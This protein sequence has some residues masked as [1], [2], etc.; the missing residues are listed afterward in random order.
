MIS[1]FETAG[2]DVVDDHGARRQRGAGDRGL[3]G[4]DAQGDVGGRRQPL[5]DGDDP[6][7][8]LVGGDWRRA[9][10]GGLPA[11]VEDVG[12]GGGEL[13]P[14]GDGGIGLEEAPAVRERVGRDVDDPHDR[15]SRATHSIPLEHLQSPS[16]APALRTV[17]K[18]AASAKRTGGYR[19]ALGPI[20]H[21]T[22]A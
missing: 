10:A 6:A 4:V 8:L 21:L 16:Q 17:G 14:V 2:G 7:G 20:W 1:G 3:R 18:A 13:D 22:H 12:T 9:G 15:R 5:D 19:R 11:D